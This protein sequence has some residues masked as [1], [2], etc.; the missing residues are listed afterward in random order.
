MRNKLAGTKKGTSK[1]AKYFQ[2]P[3]NIASK[4]KKDAYNKAYHATPERKKYRADLQ[5]KNREAG[6]HGNGDNKDM[7]HVSKTKTVPQN[8]SKNRGNKKKFL[9]GKASKK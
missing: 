6:T 2:D 7:G 4:K 9:F 8:A 3:K 1:S 5:K